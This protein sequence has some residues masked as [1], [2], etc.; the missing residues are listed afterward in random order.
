MSSKDYRIPDIVVLTPER[1]SIDRNEY[2]EG[3]PEVVVEIRSP[4]DETEEKLPFYA[5]LGVP[6]VW[7]IDRDSSVVCLHRLANAAYALIAVDAHGWHWSV[8]T[9]IGLRTAS[10]GRFCLQVGYDET[11]RETIPA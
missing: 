6:E 11:S 8:A 7:V 9:G 1:A 5:E 2:F 3:A 4:G 10:D